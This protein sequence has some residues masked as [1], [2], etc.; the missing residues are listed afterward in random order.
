MP[1]LPL[2]GGCLCGGVRFEISEPLQS[3]N[4]CH[5]TRC[6]RRTGGAAS[7]Q[8]RIAPGSLRVL[9]G[10]ELLRA[11]RPPDGFAKVFCSAC[12]SGLWSE[13]PDD[14][15]VKGVRLGAFDG[16]PGVRPQWRQFVAYAAPWEP[17]PDDGLPRFP[18]RRTG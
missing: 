3:A 7:A 8:G 10:E 9:Q 1:E 15:E 4:W 2:T 14:P 12:G 5:C 11:Y 18:E 17:I 16:D 6:Q 13:S